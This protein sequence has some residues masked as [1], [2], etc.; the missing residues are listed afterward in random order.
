MIKIRKV[1]I[2]DIP[3]VLELMK[4]LAIFEGYIDDFAID[5]G[6][7]LERAFNKKEPDFHM[8]VAEE[9]K[10]ICG[11]LVYYFIP[12]SYFNKPILYLKELY[13]DENYRGKDIGNM[14]MNRVKEIA[15][16][17]DCPQIKWTVADWNENGKKFYQKIGAKESR[18]W[19]N[20]YLEVEL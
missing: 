9:E 20:Y 16:E 12:F 7:I 10:N 15:K 13:I 17:N 6:I 2:A 5:E 19:I 8:L 14:I 4:K 3:V 1:E 18:D 11:M